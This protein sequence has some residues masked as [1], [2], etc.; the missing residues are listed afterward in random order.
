MQLITGLGNPGE[1][2]KDTPHNIGFRTLDY[3]MEQLGLQGYQKRFESDFQR[4][5]ENG[6]TSFFQKPRTYMNRSGEPIATC[7]RFFKIPPEQ[8]LVICD[9]LDLSAGK[10]RFRTAGGH[11]GHNGLRSIIESLGSDKFLRARIGI[12]RPESRAQVTR[13]VLGNMEESR[14]K[15]C[16]MSMEKVVETLLQFVRHSSFKSTSISVLDKPPETPG[17]ES[18]NLEDSTK[19]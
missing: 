9:D 10:A 15:L 19:G 2:F 11:G 3:L 1:A 6:I 12:G 17:T 18:R 7:A 13:Y 4:F 16:L 8:I 5:T 14:E